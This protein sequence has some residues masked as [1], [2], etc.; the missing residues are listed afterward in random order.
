MTGNINTELSQQKI[1]EKRAQF[2]TGVKR[3]PGFKH[4]S[5]LTGFTGLAVSCLSNWGPG[6]TENCSPVRGGQGVIAESGAEL[7]WL[8]A[9][10]V[11]GHKAIDIPNCCDTTGNSLV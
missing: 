5:N 6:S 9:S 2:G 4:A 1:R 3:R 11:I 7:H 8:R 10:L